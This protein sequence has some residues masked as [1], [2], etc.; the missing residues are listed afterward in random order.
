MRLMEHDEATA[1][2]SLTE[3]EVAILRL[4]AA[5][6]STNKIAESL[7]LKPPTIMWYRK[8][9][10]AKFDVHNAAAFS[11]EMNRRGII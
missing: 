8:R 1:P 9:L 4:I 7:G 6:L 3:Q 11:T 10:Y 2:I 5:G